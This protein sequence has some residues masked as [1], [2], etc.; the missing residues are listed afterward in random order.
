[1][2]ELHLDGLRA[3]VTAGASGI[4]R[5]IAETFTAAGARVHVCDV[6]TAALEQT[7]DS[8]AAVAATPCD[9]ADVD[10]V[11]RLFAEVEESLGGLDV[12]VNNAGIAGP[13]APVD[14]IAVD[15]WRRCIDVDLSGAFY[16]TRLAVPLLKAAGGGSIVNM[17]SVAGRLGFPLRTPYAA[18]KWGLVGFTKSLALELGRDGIRVN[19]I[20]PG[21]VEGDR[22]ES[23]IEAKAL[24]LGITPDEQR[25]RMLANV[26]MR[27]TVTPQEIADTALFL[28]SDAG[29][30]ITGQAISVC[31]GVE[32]L[33]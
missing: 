18:A 2:T 23:V 22:I 14:E 28:V 1:M 12:L 9:V 31:A 11:A 13:T 32:T 16:C 21:G 19:A 4:G 3:V 30:H 10:Q 15:D 7:L 20:Q 29:R 5:V 27:S 33:A 6:D 17:S 26:A 8:G 25:E 24:A